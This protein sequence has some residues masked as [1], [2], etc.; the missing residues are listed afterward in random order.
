[1]VLCVGELVL[2]MRERSGRYVVYGDA[3]GRRGYDE[4]ARGLL[5]VARFGSSIA[6]AWAEYERSLAI[7]KAKNKHETHKI[8]LMA[9]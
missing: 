3:C 4:R 6:C 2:H 8:I 9:L 1:M 7:G 5:T